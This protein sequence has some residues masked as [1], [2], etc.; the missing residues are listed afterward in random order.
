ME[1][2]Q[3]N[4]IH[5][6]FNHNSSLMFNL[7]FVE[8]Q[9]KVNFTISYLK[10]IALSH[11]GN[12]LVEPDLLHP[13]AWAD[14]YEEFIWELKTYF[15]SPDLVSKAENKL[16]NIIMKPTQHTTKYLNSGVVVLFFI[17]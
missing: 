3:P 7:T 12:S 14:N 8:D 13:L 1:Q 9:R 2:I 15:G 5:S 11:F 4:S 10:G 6:S 16:E 17:V